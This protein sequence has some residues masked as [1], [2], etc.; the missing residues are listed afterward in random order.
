[1]PGDTPPWPFAKSMKVGSGD[2]CEKE[3][4]N[5]KKACDGAKKKS[6]KKLDCSSAAGGEDACIKA[7]QCK[8]VPKKDDKKECCSPHNTGHHL[9]PENC[10]KGEIPGYKGKKAPTVCA[11]GHSWHRKCK[12]PI[13]NAEKTHPALH[14]IQDVI[15]RK[16]IRVAKKLKSL[17]KLK[18]RTVKRPWKYKDVKKVALKAHRDVF[19]DHCS[20]DCIAAQLDE[21]HGKE[22]ADQERPLKAKKFGNKI[23]DSDP[24]LSSRTGY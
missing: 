18:D 5:E 19:G 7:K 6:R 4:D 17:G 13:P 15:T 24:F 16:V 2:P 9:I 8:M 14:E 23:N 22:V 12:S 11:G 1:M 21:Y 3:K 20:K 10:C